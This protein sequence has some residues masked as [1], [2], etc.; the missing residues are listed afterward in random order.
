VYSS[1]CLW[2]VLGCIDIYEFVYSLY[3]KSFTVTTL[4]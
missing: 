1:T 4:L 2:I 3:K